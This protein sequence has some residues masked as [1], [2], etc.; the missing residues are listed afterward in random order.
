MDLAGE[1]TEEEIAGITVERMERRPGKGKRVRR[2]EQFRNS[3]GIERSRLIK[4]EWFGK[5]RD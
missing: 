1:D 3:F 4:K 5:G 2:G